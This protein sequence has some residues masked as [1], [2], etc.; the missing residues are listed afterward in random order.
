PLVRQASAG[1]VATIGLLPSVGTA[2]LTTPDFAELI[3]GSIRTVAGALLLATMPAIIVTALAGYGQ[4]GFRVTPQAMEI[5]PSKVSIIKGF[6]RLFSMRSVVR[7]SMAAAKV[8]A[9]ATV[10]AAVA[11]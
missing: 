3:A 2:E 10:V 4:I 7:I 1:I 11:W 6:G 5:D 9:I 8:S